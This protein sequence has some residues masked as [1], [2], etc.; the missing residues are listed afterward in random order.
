MMVPGLP[1][2]PTLIY[3]RRDE[4]VKALKAADASLRDAVAAQEK[5]PE[6]QRTDPQA[7]LS[8]MAEY[9]RDLVTEQMASAITRLASPLH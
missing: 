3:D 9:L 8:V 5:L 2:L 7:D 4:Y 1:T 6:D